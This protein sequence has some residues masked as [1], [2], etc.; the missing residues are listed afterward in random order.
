M[1]LCRLSRR[2]GNI[3]EGKT[4]MRAESGKKMTSFLQRILGR[5]KPA[6]QALSLTGTP[7]I[8]AKSA[9][10][11]EEEP[12][13]HAQTSEAESKLNSPFAFVDPKDPFAPQEIA[14]K[15]VPGTMLRMRTA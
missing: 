8:Q 12:R 6:H 1:R 14:E 7:A 15:K 11:P 2:L 9:E 13:H 5:K 10:A 3:S 4:I